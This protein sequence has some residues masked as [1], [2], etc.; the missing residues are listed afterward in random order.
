M[1]GREPEIGVLGQ[2]HP[3]SLRR[4]VAAVALV[5]AAA[6]CTTPEDLIEPAD[7]PAA[8]GETT[9][10]AADE[11][12]QGG[13]ASNEDPDAATTPEPPRRP[14]PLEC[15][16]M[17]YQG[18]LA[19]T[20]SSKPVDCQ[21]AHTAQ[22]FA[23]GR[24]DTAVDGHLLA[25]DSERVQ[26][27][28]ADTCPDRLAE[29][30]GTDPE[31]LDLTM[32]RPVWFT[33]TV[34]ESDLGADWYR[35]DAV[36]LH[37]PDK[38]A[39]LTGGGLKNALADEDALDRLGVC[40]RAEPGTEGFAPLLCREQ[41]SWRAVERVGLGGLSDDSYPGQEA[42]RA[43][44]QD[45]CEQAGRE[46]ADDPLDFEWAYEWP[47]AEQWRDGQRFGRCWVPD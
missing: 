24:L 4:L 23:V 11:A 13:E 27:Q 40:S 7:E 14:E 26:Q 9:S 42:V 39:R 31:T 28:V 19:P 38:L 6:G 2:D 47:T 29:F 20:N 16:R 34:E 25:V 17:A 1:A 8:E 3:V 35:C 36:V 10:G 32:V 18:A 15:R 33:P 37:S 5:L 44:G 43:A 46:I 22:T 45:T 21:Q 41:H 30:L 12:E